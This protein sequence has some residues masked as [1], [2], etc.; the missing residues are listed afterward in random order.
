MKELIIIGGGPAGLTASIYAARKNMDFA[1]ITP[2]IGGQALWGTDIDNYLGYHMIPGTEL[3]KK[4]NEHVDAF[5]IDKIFN[6]VTSIENKNAHFS[7]G[8]K[9]QQMQSQSVIFAAGKR[10]RFLTVPGEEEFHGRG[11]TYC[12]TCDAPLFSGMPALVAGGGNAGLEAALQL[13]RI[14]PK[15]YL[16]TEEEIT[17]DRV[18][19]QKLRDKQNVEIIPNSKI[20]EI[21]GD[22]LVRSVIIDTPKGIRELVVNGV[23]IE[24]GAI[25][26][27]SLVK[28]LVNLNEKMEIKVNC[29]NETKTPGL[30][31]AGDVTNVPEKQIIIAAG[32]GAKAALSAYSYVCKVRL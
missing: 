7:I 19:E 6:K 21:K 14:S 5:N 22:N 4:F 10:P 3:V 12:S 18:T 13:S 8:F 30:F 24:I 9:N 27:C 1:L 2:S 17:G 31:A 16:V 26:N 15:V 32:E 23:F 20:K 11:V 28:D 29:S 25:P